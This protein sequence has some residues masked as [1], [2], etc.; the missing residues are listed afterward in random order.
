MLPLARYSHEVFSRCNPR[1]Q[2]EDKGTLLS[3][4]FAHGGVG[5]V[6]MSS[7]REHSK[8]ARKL[9]NMGVY[10]PFHLVRAVSVQHIILFG[11]TWCCSQYMCWLK[12]RLTYIRLKSS[13]FEV[14]LFAPQHCDLRKGT[15]YFVDHFSLQHVQIRL[16]NAICV[17]GEIGFQLIVGQGWWLQFCEH[18]R[19]QWFVY[20]L[21]AFFGVGWVGWGT[22][23]CQNSC[24]VRCSL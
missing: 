10:D 14:L 12:T 16:D 2:A 9:Y 20:L 8:E 1:F 18:V 15:T 13:G 5:S 6:Q 7:I 4:A 21:Y 11:S 22:Q 23:P 19:W 3:A 17:L 24:V